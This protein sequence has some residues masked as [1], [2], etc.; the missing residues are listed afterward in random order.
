MVKMKKK[1]I[2]TKKKRIQIQRTKLFRRISEVVEYVFVDLWYMWAMG[3]IEILFV[4][5]IS[6]NV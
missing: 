1:C 3:I 6:V 2:D 5:Y 4:I